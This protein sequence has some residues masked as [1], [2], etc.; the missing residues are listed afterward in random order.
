M[1]LNLNLFAIGKKLIVSATVLPVLA[2]AQGPKAAPTVSGCTV[3]PADNVWNARIDSLPVDPSSNSYVNAEGGSALP[4]HPD[5]GTVYDGAPN[6]LPFLVVPSTQPAVPIVFTQ[7]GDQSDPG[8]Y[9]IPANAPV[10]GGSA[11]TGDRHVIVLQSGTCQLY[12]MFLAYLQSDGSWQASNGALFNLNADSPLRPA[13]WTSADAA[14]LPIFPGLVRYDEVQQALAADGVLHHALRFTVPY[15]RAQYLWPARHFA[16]GST[17]PAYPPMGQRFRLKAGVSIGTY[18]G[19]NVPVSPTNMVILQTLQQ[20]GMFLADNGGGILGLSGAPDSRWSDA[21]LHELVL[22]NAADFEAVDES[23]LQVNPN[24]GAAAGSGAVA[25]TATFLGTDSSTKGN[26]TGQYGANGQIIP[27][28]LTNTPSYA[29][30]S[31]TGDSVWTWSTYTTDPRALQASSGSSSRISSTFYGSSPFVIDLNLT[32]GNIHKISLYLCDWDNGNRVETITVVDAASQAVLSTQAVSSFAGGV[33]ESWNVQGHVQIEVTPNSG[34]NAIVNAIFFDTAPATTSMTASAAYQGADSTTLGNWTGQYGVDGQI[35]ASDVTN[36]PSYASVSL[37]GDSIWTWTTSTTDPRALQAS[38]GSSSRI[39]STFYSYSPFVINVNLTDGNTHK[40]SLY[41]CDWDKGSRVETITILD[42]VS[43]AVLST[44]TFSALTG[45]VYESW[46]IRGNVQIVVTP[47]SGV[48][49]IANAIF[50]DTPGATTTTATASA[51]YQGA[52]SRTLGNW[53]GQ[54]GADGEIIANDVTNS[55]SYASV[56]LTADF[57]WTWTTYTT[58]PRALQASSGSSAR[59]SSTFYSPGPFVLD[60]N[61]TDGNPHKISLYLCDW[62]S[63][64]RVETITIVDAGSQAALSTQTFSSF[65]GGVY[66][67][68]NIQGHVQIK[69]IPNSG[70]NAIVNAIFFD[71]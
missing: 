16:S 35:I 54:Y 22:Y 43:Q 40:I 31:L 1:T 5:F 9:P 49:A 6:G 53:T 27:N 56:S 8:P 38:S 7:Y 11:G 33:Y 28:D 4:L 66:Q 18:P 2:L 3:F 63:G 69:V 13:G 39:S 41:L 67:V 10:E 15:T 21:D 20:Y 62:D 26:W 24:S 34:I 44:Q 36:T 68:W 65:A 46:N 37:T 59:I 61:L 25:A 30:V 51:A 17:N 12:E 50:F 32:D 47:N 19:T 48:N 14:G 45:G 29:S 42:A 71:P 64:G 23:S 60:V 52:D 55:P 58:D 70:I 57:T